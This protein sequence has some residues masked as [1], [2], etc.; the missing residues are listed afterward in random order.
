MFKVGDQVIFRGV[1]N[2][3]GVIGT[4]KSIS[5]KHIKV[6][7][8]VSWADNSIDDWHDEDE[9]SLYYEDEPPNLNQ[10]E[11]LITDDQFDF[12]VAL[13]KLSVIG[14]T[15][16]IK[17]AAIDLIDSLEENDLVDEGLNQEEIWHAKQTEDFL[18]NMEK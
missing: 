9:L 14:K 10:S 8:K 4:V 2:D 18:N 15:Q 13:H 17:Q 5:N 11:D 12:L 16:R 7:W 1:D 3:H 6:S